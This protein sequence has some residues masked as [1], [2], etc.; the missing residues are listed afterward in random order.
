MKYRNIKSAIHNF[1]HSFISDENYVDEDYVPYELAAI[2][3]QGHQ[4][5][6]NWF[7]RRF[8]PKGLC[9]PRIEKSIGYWADGLSRLLESQNVDMQN[10]KSLEFVWPIDAAHFMVAVDDHGVEHKKV[11]RYAG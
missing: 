7:T 8:E 10:L 6:I 2:H 4:I 3:S 5:V 11:V 1:G 9:T